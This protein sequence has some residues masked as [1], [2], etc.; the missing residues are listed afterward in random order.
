MYN[1][2]LSCIFYVWARLFRWTLKIYLNKYKPVALNFFILLFILQ[3][4]KEQ[5]TIDFY[6]CNMTLLSITMQN[7]LRTSN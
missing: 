2:S 7:R 6:G 5:N 3:K 4:V 1:L